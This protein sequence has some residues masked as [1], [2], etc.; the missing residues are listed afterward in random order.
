MRLITNVFTAIA[1]TAT[2]EFIRLII[3]PAIGLGAGY[4]FYQ[5]VKD[6]VR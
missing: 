2:R 5:W 1:R 3:G 4:V 6:V